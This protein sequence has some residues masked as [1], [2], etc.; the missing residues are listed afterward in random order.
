[1]RDR[2]AHTKLAGFTLLEAMIA[3][4]IVALGMMAVLFSGV[5][6]VD[7]ATTSADAVCRDHAEL[8]AIID[9]LA[10]VTEAPQ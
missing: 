5:R 4:A 6:D 9:R 10:G 7:E 2:R 8:P 3:L 1:M